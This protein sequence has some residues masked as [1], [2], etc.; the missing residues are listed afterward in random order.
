MHPLTIEK[1]KV[2]ARNSWR[3]ASNWVMTG[4]GIGFSA[5]LGLPDDQKEALVQHLPVPLWTVPIAVSVVGV[6][7]RVWPQHAISGQ[8]AEAKSAD[9]PQPPAAQ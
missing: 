5:Y 2:N 6:A 7:A 1:L 4:A 8:V 3:M 9:A